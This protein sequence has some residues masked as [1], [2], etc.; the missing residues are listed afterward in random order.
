[1]TSIA[2]F[3]NTIPGLSVPPATPVSYESICVEL[4]TSNTNKGRAT[5][6]VYI[7]EFPLACKRARY[8]PNRCRAGRSAKRASGYL[9]R[10]KCHGRY[11]FGTS[12]RSPVMLPFYQVMSSSYVS[13]YNG[14]S[15]GLNYGLNGHVN[16]PL[17]DDLAMRLVGYRFDNDG[18]R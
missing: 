1:M 18:Y 10:A 15:D 13:S 2:D 6:S 5:T 17:A 3:L 14:D 9:V 4:R 11:Q 12:P 7:D 8:S 16:V